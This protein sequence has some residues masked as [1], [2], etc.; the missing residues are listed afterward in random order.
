MFRFN[1]AQADLLSHILDTSCFTLAE[2]EKLKPLL[3]KRELP[4]KYMRSLS[5]AL[6]ELGSQE[7]KQIYKDVSL[8]K[9]VQ[10]GTILQPEKEKQRKEV[11]YLA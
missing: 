5:N 7:G 9:L 4:L 11:R 10:G 2:K 3:Q 6:H 8:H 1:D